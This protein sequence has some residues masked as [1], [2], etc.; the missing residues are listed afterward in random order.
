MPVI[1]DFVASMQWTS[2]NQ[3]EAEAHHKDAL[4]LSEEGKVSLELLDCSVSA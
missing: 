3:K 1:I 4:I 2:A